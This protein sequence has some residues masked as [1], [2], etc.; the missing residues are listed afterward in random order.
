MQDKRRDDTMFTRPPI[1]REHGSWAM[2]LMPYVVGLSV[3]GSWGWQAAF[4]LVSTLALFL[5]RYP[6]SLVA[7]RGFPR[8]RDRATRGLYGWLVAY[9]VVA[10]ISG[11]AL[12]LLDRWLMVLLG[13]LSVLL[14][15]AN[16]YFSRHKL[17]RAVWA[18]LVVIAGLSLTAPGAYY[19]ATGELG[20][21]VLALWMLTSLYSG[22]SVFYV[23]LRLHDRRA[24]P[25]PEQRRRTQCAL[26]LYLGMLLT[27]VAA[28]IAVGA[29]PL[30]VLPAFV[31]LLYKALRAIGG[32]R[33]AQM[34]LRQVGFTELG[35]AVAFAVLVILAFRL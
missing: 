33:A 32:Q 25:Q 4:F 30:L 21:T 34:T 5:A 24:Q 8:P 23:R 6:L 10:L 15:L 16:L 19:A 7:R 20:Q 27:G 26:L 29:A 28:L 12:L 9:T 17:D 14:L 22:S 18:E 35:H 2:L 13:V 3:A 1:P 31:P 11:V